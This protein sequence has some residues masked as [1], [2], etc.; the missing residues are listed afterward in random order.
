[1]LTLHL[2]VLP[3][4]PETTF[5]FHIDTQA[6][7]LIIYPAQQKLNHIYLVLW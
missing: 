5:A 7:T 3:D 6:D 4:V 2:C 1:M